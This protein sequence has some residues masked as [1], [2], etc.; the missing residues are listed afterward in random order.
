MSALPPLPPNV[1][2]LAAPQLLGGVW[3]WCLYGVLAV[4]TYVYSYN[5]S[6]DS[7][8][9]KCLVYGVF[10]LETLQTALSGADLYYW[11]ASGFGKLDHLASPYL[12][13]F[14]VPIIGSVVSLTVQFFFVYR[15]WVLSE[16]KS[17]WLCFLIVLCSVV[18]SIG[19]FTG[20]TLTHVRGRFVTGR[21]LKMLALTWLV[22][23][24]V[25]DILIATAMLTQRKSRVGSFRNHA[26]V[27][28]V[29]L[30]IES[31]IATTTVSVASLLM[32]ALYPDKNCT[33]VLG[34]IYSNTLLVSLNNRILI[35]EKTASEGAIHSPVS[36]FPSTTS[37]S[38][39]TTDIILMDMQKPLQT[40]KV[41]PLGKHNISERIINIA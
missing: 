16:K 36:T 1:E 20:G 35:R 21:I 33:S 4:Q 11:F 18:S 8:R 15:I 3:N 10:F 22:G 24:T 13:F 23:N 17:W 7:R 19:A 12:T 40:L 2:E 9:V 34:K 5:F 26:L 30:T 39:A 37:R 14:D 6:K 41:H 28:I 29:R 31:N 27:S 25:S 32:V 38:E